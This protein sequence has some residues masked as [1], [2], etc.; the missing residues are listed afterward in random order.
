MSFLF[1]TL[2]M[3]HPVYEFPWLL[4]YNLIMQQATVTVGAYITTV[5]HSTHIKFGS[6][7]RTASVPNR[8]TD[9]INQRT[10]KTPLQ[11]DA[12]T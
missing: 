12:K 3:K 4:R 11:G 8:R 2:R 10:F 6:I 1:V 9:W 7:T 5:V